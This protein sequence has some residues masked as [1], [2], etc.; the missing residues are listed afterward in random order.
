MRFVAVTSC[1]TGIAHTYMAAEALALAAE[2]AGHD[3]TVET[4]GAI[5]ADPIDQE[6]IAAADAVIF[7]ADLEVKD[8][9]RF[10][11]LPSVDVGVK[12]AVHDANGLIEQAVAAATAAESSGGLKSVSAQTISSPTIRK[13]GAG[14][15]I[16]QYLMT[17]V[18]HMIP[19]VAAGGLLIA[20]G[21]LI[22]TVAWPSD[23]VVAV[24]KVVDGNDPAAFTSWVTAQFGF[25][26]LQSWAVLLF[27][28]GKWSFAFLV[29]ALSA[30]IAYAI[31]DRPGIA[32]GFVGGFAAGLMGTGFLGGIVTGFL[33]GFLALWISRWKVPSGVRGIMPVVVIPLLSVAITCIATVLAVGPPVRWINE[34]LTDTLNSMSGGSAV[35]LGIALG[36]MQCFDLGGPV[37]KVAYVFATT[38]LVNATSTASAPAHIMAAVMAAGMVP[39]LAIA[40]ATVLRPNV[41]TK[42]EREAGKSCW[43]LGAS[44]I[45]EGAIPFAA[46]DP[47]RMIPSF[48]LGGGVAGGLIMAF[49]VG[50]LA[51][52]G[53]IWVLPLIGKPV[54]FVAALV[55]GFA[56]SAIAVLVAKQ[57]GTRNVAA[58]GELG[59]NAAVA[60]PSGV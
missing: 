27:W 31:A 6:V 3:I 23:G 50:Q 22:A 24:T 28:I 36:L 39:P 14:S 11:G 33:G 54:L 12:A 34:T 52:H 60:S 2:A 30:Y 53:G 19:F 26:S 37:N 58:A 25:F 4:Q 40:L 41:W 44:F 15:R 7:A 49:G 8:K 1:P 16:R 48:M 59:P 35:V 46:A 47:I 17:G 5:G 56:T 20:A 57:F 51:P 55:A 38:G 9:A 45:S 13:A 10:S 32:P 29:P 42:Q 18:S 21:F 43:L